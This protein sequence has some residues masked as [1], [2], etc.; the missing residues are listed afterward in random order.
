MGK[1]I[2]CAG[3]KADTPF[4]VNEAGINADTI[5]ELCYCLRQNLDLVDSS[6]V[7][8]N[9]AAYISKDLGLPDRGG[10]LERLINSRASLKEKLMTVFES[11]SYYD[12]DELMTIRDEIEELSKMSSLERRKRRADRQMRQG[13]YNEAAEEY[14]NILANPVQDGISESCRGDIMYNLGIF[15]IRSGDFDEAARLF[16]EAYESN[17]NVESLKSYLYVLKLAKNNAGYADEVKR[18]EVDIKIYNEIENT[19]HSVGEDFEQSNNYNEINRMRVLWQQGRY[20]EEK[21]L[22]GEIIDRLKLVYRKEN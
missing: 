9:M 22:S 16:L 13:K 21:R 12:A 15:E 17:S 8:R 5:E 7:D 19:M 1:V 20:S 10:M 2:L 14:R 3:K 6:A 11:C 4:V 18:L